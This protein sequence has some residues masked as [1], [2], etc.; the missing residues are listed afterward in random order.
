MN[1][2]LAEEK[3]LFDPAKEN[4][5]FEP[6]QVY[7]VFASATQRLYLSYAQSYDTNTLK[8][9]LFETNHGILDDPS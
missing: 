7:L 9:S 5:S 3:F 2:R 8:I 6:L 1:A 4:L